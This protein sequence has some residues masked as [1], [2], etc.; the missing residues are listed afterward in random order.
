MLWTNKE[1][2]IRTHLMQTIFIQLFINPTTKSTETVL[3]LINMILKEIIKSVEAIFSLNYFLYI[4]VFTDFYQ[5]NN[6][7][8]NPRKSAFFIRVFD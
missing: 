7:Q 3:L 1:L 6:M 4:N 8:C 5:C 2:K